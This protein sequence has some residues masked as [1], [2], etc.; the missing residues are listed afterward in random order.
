MVSLM[1]VVVDRWFRMAGK[2][3]RC[4]HQRCHPLRAVVTERT[5]LAQNQEYFWGQLDTSVGFFSWSLPQD[6]PSKQK[7]FKFEQFDPEQRMFQCGAHVPLMIFVGANK[8]ANARRTPESQTL[9]NKEAGARRWDHQR[10]ESTKQWS[11]ASI[12]N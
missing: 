5:A 11:R 9:R 6:E 12:D 1:T 10:S 8:E 7:L 2:P 4:I 3:Q